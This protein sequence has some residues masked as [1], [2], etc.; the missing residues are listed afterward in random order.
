MIAERLND[1]A[2]GA[3]PGSVLPIGAETLESSHS[4]GVTRSL[5]S[6]PCAPENVAVAHP[7]D[8]QR[9]YHVCHGNILAYRNSPL[10]EGAKSIYL[11]ALTGYLPGSPARSAV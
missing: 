3:R 4:L 5:G 2:V 9:V 11:V 10:Q 6:L 8:R 1:P 7:S